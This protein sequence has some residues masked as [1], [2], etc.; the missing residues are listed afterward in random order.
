MID[1]QLSADQEQQGWLS[2]CQSRARSC[3]RLAKMSSDATARAELA[4]MAEEW[5]A[6][7]E[8]DPTQWVRLKVE[9]R[10]SANTNDAL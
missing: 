5:N 1:R 7:A 3:H 8:L 4:K 2:F 6:A 10:T 9:R